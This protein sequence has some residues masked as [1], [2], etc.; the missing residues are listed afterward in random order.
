MNLKKVLLT[1]IVVF[2]CYEAMFAQGRF[3]WVREKS[4]IG[5]FDHYLSDAVVDAQGNIFLWV[6]SKI[7]CLLQMI[8]F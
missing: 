7:A 2:F 8:H 5:P 4:T 1:I 6:L 3:E